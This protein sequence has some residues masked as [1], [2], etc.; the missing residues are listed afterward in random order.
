MT[1]LRSASPHRRVLVLM[2]LTSTAALVLAAVIYSAYQLFELR[3][4]LMRETR[5][6][7]DMVAEN[8]SMLLSRR[9]GE[10]FD[11][12]LRLLR[13]APHVVSARVVAPDGTSLAEFD[14]PMA[15][16]RGSGHHEQPRVVAVTRPFLADGQRLGSV[17]IET[18]M[19]GVYQRLGREITIGGAVLLASFG[20][21]L[22]VAA[23]TGSR[24]VS[25]LQALATQVAGITARHAT[26][27]A[28]TPPATD[29]NADVAALS[30]ALDGLAQRLVRM[31]RADGLLTAV[32][33]ASWD[34]HYAVDAYGHIREANDRACEALGYA[35]AELVGRPLA[36]VELKA[37]HETLWLGLGPGELRRA[38]GLHRRK[39]GS[40]IAVELR[41]C[42]VDAG[43]D[44]RLVVLA[45]DATHAAQ[46][47]RDAE[48]ARQAV[49]TAARAKRAFLHNVN[50]EFRTPL[51]AVLGMA[52]LLAR[53]EPDSTRQRYVE[54]IQASATTLLGLV[55]DLL[56]LSWLSSGSASLDSVDLGV[57]EV[58]EDVI[59][60]LSPRAAAKGL[61]LSVLVSPEVPRRARGAERQLR[62]A[63][64][65]LVSNAVKFTERGEVALAVE[66]VPR[67]D[68]EL[69]LEF[70]V[71]DTGPGV[72]E[73][74][75]AALLEPFKDGLDAGDGAGRTGGLGIG[76]ALAGTLVRLMGGE[77]LVTSR[78]G[79]GSR[80]SFTLHLDAVPGAEGERD[81]SV[82][83]LSGRSALVFDPDEMSLHNVVA[84]LRAVGLQV[85]AAT[86]AEAALERLEH[87]A[88]SGSR[89]DLLFVPVG[90][91]RSDPVGL[92]EVC[93]RAASAHIRLV[94]LEGLA[95]RESGQLLSELAAD[96]VLVRPLRPSRL[97]L[98]LAGVLSGEMVGAGGS[99]SHQV[100]RAGTLDVLVVDSQRV[101]RETLRLML[102]ALGHRCRLTGSVE[103][104][105]EVLRDERFDAVFLDCDL[106]GGAAYRLAR[107]LRRETVRLQPRLVG[108]SADPGSGSRQLCI[109]AGMDECLSKP[110]PLDVLQAALWRHGT[111]RSG[112]A[113]MH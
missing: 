3:A 103:E 19:A 50:R 65:H 24:I 36:D 20:L 94:L 85:D 33:S 6:L 106:A 71:R 58:C 84:Q 76:L 26:V 56:E 37:D 88:R 45:R 96:L 34:L 28:A 5:Q 51:T 66:L 13:R 41:A 92:R 16:A 9:D 78:P 101:V 87:A 69:V 110:V 99:A 1:R 62:Q 89:H 104:A 30:D 63:L 108:L 7:A 53:E 40:T 38:D 72:P 61:E 73:D 59:D 83:A 90:A 4:Q 102:T 46:A 54:V 43:D 60:L 112:A 47:S 80:F 23:R 21:A 107:V 105:R 17:V 18:D 64:V 27:P 82:A 15:A 81:R 97:P 32:L 39:N 57:A 100:A 75:V 35:R 2:S 111:E 44:A 70:S 113:G 49:E 86:D 74:I 67:S 68:D 109:E 52:E 91:E 25:P 22:F 12:A 55:D 31:E 93:A 42:R 48:R 8:G 11:K 10:S 98:A 29:S 14:G 79:V 77:L 95:S